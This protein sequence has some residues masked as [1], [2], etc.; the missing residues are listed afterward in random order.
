M[1]LVGLLVSLLVLALIFGVAFWVLTLFR[2]PEP[3]GKV[4]QVILAVVF[5][6]VLLGVIFGGVSIPWVTVR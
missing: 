4:A 6:L 5:V 1:S 3:F 2:L